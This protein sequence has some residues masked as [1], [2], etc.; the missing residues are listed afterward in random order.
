MLSRL[1]FIPFFFFLI[2]SK[3]DCSAQICAGVSINTVFP[4]SGPENTLVTIQGSGFLSGPTLNAVSFN[5]IQTTQFTVVSNTEIKVY[6]PSAAVSGIVSLV[7]NSC[8]FNSTLSF[9]V[10]GSANCG[11]LASDI[12]ISEVYDAGTGSLTYIELYNATG[13]NINLSNYTIQQFNNGNATPGCSRSLSGTIAN[14][15]TFIISTGSTGAAADLNLSSGPGACGGINQD[16]C[17]KLIKNSSILDSW[18]VCDGSN[19][20]I[21]GAAGYSYIRNSTVNNPSVNY[22]PS[23]WQA[24]NNESLAD[25][26]SHTYSASS[27]AVA[28]NVTPLSV[29]ICEGENASFSAVTN[30][31]GLTFQWKMLNAAGNWVN[32]SN[33]SE[34]SGVNTQ[35]LN[36]L[37]ANVNLHNAQ[38]YC[39][40]SDGT[41]VRSSIASQISIKDK[42]TTT[43]I[44]H[45]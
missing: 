21:G 17:I 44:S 20:V 14:N 2:V 23:E 37:T 32:L 45:N 27:S 16:D 35:N 18:G 12:F 31:A 28:I 25:I 4:T 34:F 1:F 13:A 6:C 30:P 38:F 36:V 8:T 3:V 40:I 22:V 19:W 7:F 43:N 29:N 11:S 24:F 9:T 42:P 26:G 41:C 39:S 15:S 10:I 5:S 33:G